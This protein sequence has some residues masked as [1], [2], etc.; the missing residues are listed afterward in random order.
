[1][2][3][4]LTVTG[5][6]IQLKPTRSPKAPSYVLKVPAWTGRELWLRWEQ[7]QE[8]EQQEQRGKPWGSGPQHN[9]LLC[10]PTKHLQHS[11]KNL[12]LPA[13]AGLARG[14]TFCGKKWEPR[15]EFLITKHLASPCLRA[16]F[17]FF[18]FPGLKVTR[19]TPTT[20][21][22]VTG[23]FSQVIEGYGGSEETPRKTKNVTKAVLKGG[24]KVLINVLGWTRK[25]ASY[26]S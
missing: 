1:M 4:S 7:A 12:N 26:R 15:Q 9:S 24:Q 2:N 16:G 22:W 13:R 11:P 21:H 19:T 18:V 8:S 17:W 10:S 5:R 3:N 6:R 20:E 25:S 23:S 14:S